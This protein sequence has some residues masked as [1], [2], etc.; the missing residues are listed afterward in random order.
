M[1]FDT[2]V[3]STEEILGS[4]RHSFAKIAKPS[5]EEY[6]SNRDY[7]VRALEAFAELSGKYTCQCWPSRP[8]RG[9]YLWDVSWRVDDIPGNLELLLVVESEW[10]KPADV[11][12][13]FHKLIVAK[14][15]LK[16]LLTDSLGHPERIRSKLESALR[17]FSHHTAGERY[18]W[19][20]VTGRPTGGKLFPFTFTAPGSE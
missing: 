14:A 2:D 13:D 20:D 5:G 11:L 12:F 15:R 19:I 17:S 3:P 9:E 6:P 4:L 7:T 1:S 10:G 18:L 8:R 16:V